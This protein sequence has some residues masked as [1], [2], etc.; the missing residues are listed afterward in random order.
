[1]AAPGAKSLK[2]REQ[3]RSSGVLNLED[4]GLPEANI[5]ASSLALGVTVSA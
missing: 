4:Q 2:V 3:N 1:M 5:A